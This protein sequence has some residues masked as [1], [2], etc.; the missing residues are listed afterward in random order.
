MN[1]MKIIKTR[2]SIRGYSSKPVSKTLI[3]DIVDCGRLAATAMNVQPWEFVAVTDK[4]LLKKI[5][6]ILPHNKFCTTAPVLILVFCKDGDYYLEDGSAA[7]ENLLLAAHAS[8][9]GACWV[10]GEKQPFAEALGKL[11]KVPKKY[12]LVSLVPVGFPAEKPEKITK[13]K[14]TEVLHWEK[15]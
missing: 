15:F 9:L 5:E 14:I 10:A 13:R 6:E 1:M 7:T 11:L 4:T 8:G 2:R 12:R 3:K